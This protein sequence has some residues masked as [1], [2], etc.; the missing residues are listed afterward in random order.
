MHSG[1]RH[2]T[3]NRL[4]RPGDGGGHGHSALRFANGR[5]DGVATGSS[6]G[7]GSGTGWNVSS[8]ARSV[9]V[10]RDA[11]G[12]FQVDARV[13]GR[14]LNFIVEIPARR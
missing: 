10:P 2:A 7:F 14:L 6:P 5:G 12:H 8:Y 9:V 11:R 3:F 13:D 1:F 4:C